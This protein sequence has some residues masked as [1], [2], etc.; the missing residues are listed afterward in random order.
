MQ[1]C[2][3]RRQRGFSA[4][5]AALIAFGLI[6]SPASADPTIIDIIFGSMEGSYDSSLGDFSATVD[7]T[8]TFGGVQ[9]L[10]GGPETANYLT[11]FQTGSSARS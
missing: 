3:K 8:R 7:N 2:K 9:R 5:A 6:A 1:D 4:G 11:G 10:F